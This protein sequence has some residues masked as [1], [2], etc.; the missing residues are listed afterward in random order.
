MFFIKHKLD[1][2]DLE[3]TI[4]ETEQ[5]RKDVKKQLKDAQDRLIDLIEEIKKSKGHG[6]TDH[7]NS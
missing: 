2:I 6:N 3:N 5:Q 7:T 4:R 1:E